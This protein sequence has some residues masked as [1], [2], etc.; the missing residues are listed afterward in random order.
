MFVAFA[1]DIPKGGSLIFSTPKGERY[2]LTRSKEEEST[3]RA[4]SSRCPHLGC[5]VL[6]REQE[7]RFF[8]PCHAGAFDE[9]GKAT[10]GPPAKAGQSLKSCEIKVV[11][12]T[13]YALVEAG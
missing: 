12:R 1:S 9:T 4:F 13:I 6:W 5:K 10:E 2:L 7:N 11:G 8:C 3:Y